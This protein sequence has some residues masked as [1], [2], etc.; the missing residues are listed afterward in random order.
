MERKIALCQ[1]GD[2]KYEK[3]VIGNWE[4]S[5]LESGSHFRPSSDEG[6]TIY[7]AYIGDSEYFSAFSK[8]ELREAVAQFIENC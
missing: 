2:L 7:Y 5:V 8:S 4:K 6:R 3:R 1:N